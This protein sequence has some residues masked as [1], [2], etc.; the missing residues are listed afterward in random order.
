MLQAQDRLHTALPEM[1]GGQRQWVCLQQQMRS[2]Q[3]HNKGTAA[4]GLNNCLLCDERICG[5]AY[6]A[7]AGA[8]RR[9]SGLVSDIGRKSVQN[10]NKTGD[11][12]LPGS[13]GSY[14]R[15]TAVTGEAH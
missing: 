9:T 12:R 1:L 3:D 15:S 5:P 11:W 4:G 7:C 14:P 6:L 8:N 2:N 13:Y 10:C